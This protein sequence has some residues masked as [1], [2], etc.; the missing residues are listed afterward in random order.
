MRRHA[1]MNGRAL[2]TYYGLFRYFI[3]FI[4]NTPIVNL[5]LALQRLHE[6]G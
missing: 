6:R 1:L 2:R 5:E 3:R 4:Y